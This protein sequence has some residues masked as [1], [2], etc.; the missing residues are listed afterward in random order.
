MIFTICK[1]FLAGCLFRS[2]SIFDG[3]VL[4]VFLYFESKSFIRY[5]FYKYFPLGL[6][7]VF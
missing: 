3:V 4:E 2:F 5:K 7:L 6:W 1:C